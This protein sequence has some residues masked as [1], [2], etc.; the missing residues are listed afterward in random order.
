MIG[1]SMC[2]CKT[3]SQAYEKESEGEPVEPG[4]ILGE[5]PDGLDVGE[6]RHHAEGDDQL[7]EEDRVHLPD[8]AVADLVSKP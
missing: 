4:V 5:G 6:E 7:H 2:M 3:F 1:K 8:E